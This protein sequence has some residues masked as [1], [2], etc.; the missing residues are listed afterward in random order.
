MSDF[1]TSRETTIAN[2][3]IAGGVYVS[4]HTADEGQEPD[5]SSEVSAAD[6]DRVNVAQA[7]W[8][9]SGSNP[10]T[11]TNDNIIS[12]GTT[13]NDWGAITHGCLWDSATGGT[14]L[15]A[16]VSISNSGATPSGVEVEISG[17]G[18]Q[19]NID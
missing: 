16:T 4:L 18:I 2:N 17:D 8:T 6:Y 1:S 15:V 3:L 14:P 7:D 10:T 11:I 5:G 9:V 13:Q 19:I 12:F